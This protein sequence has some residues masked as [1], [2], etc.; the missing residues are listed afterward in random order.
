M[1][2]IQ[3]RFRNNTTVANLPFAKLKNRIAGHVLDIGVDG[4]RRSDAVY[5]MKWGFTNHF[6]VLIFPVWVGEVGGF[7]GIGMREVAGRHLQGLKNMLLH[8]TFPRLARNFPNQISG[9]HHQHVVVVVSAAKV[10][11]ALQKA[12][13]AYEVFATEVGRVPN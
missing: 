11:I 8:K 4:S 5:G 6:G 2:Q 10:S 3:I 7:L 9:G 1:R 12:Q 13:P